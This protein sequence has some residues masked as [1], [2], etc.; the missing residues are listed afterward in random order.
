MKRASFLFV[1]ITAFSVAACS[2][3]DGGTPPS[4][5]KRPYEGRFDVPVRAVPVTPPGPPAADLSQRL[6]R[7]EADAAKGQSEFS[8]ERAV[9]TRAV[10][11]ASGAAVGSE[12][13]VVAQQAISRMIAARAPSTA[14]LADLDRLYLDR[15][16][17]E[18][19]DGM[20]EIFELRQ[21]LAAMVD[22]QDEVI[23]SLTAALK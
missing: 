7:W 17:A 10:T 12:A 6:Q 5:A 4:L 14:A 8:D 22:G 3:V 1:L 11:A 23:D 19:F 21:R 2:T 13:W 16:D 18:S 15:S 20:P 9:A